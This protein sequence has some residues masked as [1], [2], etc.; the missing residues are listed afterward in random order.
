ML[1]I[2]KP[3]ACSEK[4]RE[5]GRERHTLTHAQTD[6]DRHRQTQTDRQTDTDRHRQTDRQTHRQTDR[7]R[8]THRHTHTQTHTHLGTSFPL[9]EFQ[10]YIFQLLAQLL[11]L[12]SAPV[13]ETYMSLFPFLTN[14]GLWESGVNTT[15]LVR[16]ICAFLKV[17]KA[18]VVTSE[19]E[20]EGLLG[21]FQKLIASKVQCRYHR[22]RHRHR[23][24]QTH[25]DTDT[26]RHTKT[27]S[28]TY[29]LA[30]IQIHQQHFLWSV[31]FLLTVPNF[32]VVLA[33]HCECIFR[34][35]G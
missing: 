10:P 1:K 17:G 32:G 18:A 7:H 14:P 11:E 22:H 9:A 23:H 21:V 3:Q 4:G 24:T 20:L 13:P 19:Q 30:R 12:R 31:S 29:T 27:R 26:H 6:T 35:F 16:F 25:T 28:H 33:L 34:R 15:P 5:K 8:H 2:C